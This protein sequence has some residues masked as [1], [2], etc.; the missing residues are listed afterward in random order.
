MLAE[1]L[2]QHA[3]RRGRGAADLAG[4]CCAARV[5]CRLHALHADPA[6][7]DAA[8]VVPGATYRDDAA[9]LL[10]RHAARALD[11]AR[12]AAL[13]GLALAPWLNLQ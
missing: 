2:V 12:D 9:H 4:A 6:Y 13:Y 7:R 3:Q 11:N 5:L 10:S 1:E 8:V